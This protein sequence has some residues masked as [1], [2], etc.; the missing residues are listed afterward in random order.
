MQ[1]RIQSDGGVPKALVESYC[2]PPGTT[3]SIAGSSTVYPLADFWSQV[4]STFCDVEFSVEGG[5]MF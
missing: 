3:I 5:G 4:Y 2:G 1:T